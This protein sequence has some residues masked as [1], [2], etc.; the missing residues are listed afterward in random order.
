MTM[1]SNENYKVTVEIDLDVAFADQDKVDALTK[2]MKAE[3]TG[4]GEVTEEQREINEYVEALQSGNVG[5]IQN[6][7]SKQFGNVKELAGDPFQFIFGKVIKK[8]GKFARA[9]LWVGI[10]LLIFEIVKFGI[11]EAM[12]PGRPLDRRFKR[13]AQH[14]IFLFNERQEQ[15]ALRQGFKEV[16]VTTI[17]GL[18]GVMAKGQVSGNLFANG[19]DIVPG[20]F[21]DQR[22]VTSESANVKAQGASFSGFGGD[23]FSGRYGSK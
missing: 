6:F 5:D 23:K 14:E 10:G 7:T 13:I 9:G 1:G 8:F 19:R 17:Q 18:R 22:I 16:R 2:G 15:Q 20:D 12:K 3:G 11:N 4:D 21:Y